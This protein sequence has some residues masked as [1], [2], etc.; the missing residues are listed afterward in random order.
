RRDDRELRDAA[1]CGDRGLELVQ[2][3]ER[4]DHEQVDAPPIEDLGLLGEDRRALLGGEALRVAEGADRA[5]DEDL[6]AGD[7][8]CLARELDPSA[9]DPLQLVL[10]VELG[11][12]A[13]VR[14]E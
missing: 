3:V 4:L 5:C 13:T 8:A 6:A 11:K 7:L 14:A 9:V 12:L 10:E 1:G 2:L